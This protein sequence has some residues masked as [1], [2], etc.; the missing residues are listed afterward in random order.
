MMNIIYSE[1]LKLKK[2]NI[3][4]IVLIGG[5]SMSLL[6]FTARLVTETHM[7]FENYAYNIEQINYLLLYVVLFSLIPA[8]VFSR[9][10]TEKTANVLYCYP[11]RRIK[12]FIAKIFIIYILISLVYVIEVASIL[13]SY[14]FLNGNFPAGHLIIKDIKANLCSLIFQFLLVPI[15][16]L[17]ANI[18]KNIMIPT[19]FGI[20]SFIISGV[21]SSYSGYIKYMPLLTPFTS[22]KYFYLDESINFNYIIISGILCFLFFITISIYEFNKKDID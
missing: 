4:L 10:F 2:S 17:I 13:L 16:I 22:V 1:F 11:V 6:M 9:E 18:S 12:I 19:V 21:F 8:Y 3:M 5:I 20:L 14:Y 15:P 7:S